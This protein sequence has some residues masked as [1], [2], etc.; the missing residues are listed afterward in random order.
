MSK[1]AILMVIGL[2]VLVTLVLLAVSAKG[3]SGESRLQ[4]TGVEFVCAR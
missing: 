3:V 2:L 4:A 1:S